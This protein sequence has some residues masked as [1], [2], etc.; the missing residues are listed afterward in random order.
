MSDKQMNHSLA[1]WRF[2]L[3][4]NAMLASRN[5]PVNGGFRHVSK[6]LLL[7]GAEC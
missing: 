1:L 6:N 4:L 2:V 7:L 5:T 3:V